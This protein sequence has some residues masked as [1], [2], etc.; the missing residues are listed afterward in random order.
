MLNIY[1]SRDYHWNLLLG[2]FKS[3]AFWSW[4]F[5]LHRGRN[6]SVSVAC[7]ASGNIG[8]FKMP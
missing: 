3:Y 5:L 7:T 4:G 6:M 8:Q 2:H 1:K